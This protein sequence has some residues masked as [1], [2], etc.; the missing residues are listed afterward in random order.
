MPHEERP[1]YQDADR[2]GLEIITDLIDELLVSHEQSCA[3]HAASSV[4][5]TA[6]F[7]IKRTFNFLDSGM[8]SGWMWP[9]TE[10]TITLAYYRYKNPTHESYSVV[11]NSN[12][13]Q[14]GQ[15]PGTLPPL[16]TNYHIEYFGKD[17][18]SKPQTRMSALNLDIL[19]ESKQTWETRDMTSY[20]AGQL[21]DELGKV[22]DLHQRQADEQRRLDGLFPDIA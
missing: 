21:F 17:R 18:E 16:Q 11:I 7:S 8:S 20:D 12:I 9:L 6:Y 5:M 19:G 10:T 22:Y 14:Q 1:E 13:H 3:E 15:Q 2:E 4:S